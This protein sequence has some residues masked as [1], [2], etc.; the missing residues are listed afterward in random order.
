MVIGKNMVT[1]KRWLQVCGRGLW[2]VALCT[3]G[4]ARADHEQWCRDLVRYYSPAGRGRLESA[5]IPICMQAAEDYDN[6][7][8]CIAEADSGSALMRCNLFINAL[9]DRIKPIL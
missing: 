7:L 3:E 5:T 6:A 8:T 1:V 9:R 4:C 2:L